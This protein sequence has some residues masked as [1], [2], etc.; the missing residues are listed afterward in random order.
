MGYLSSN[1]HLSSGGAAPGALSLQM[2]GL[3]WNSDGQ[4]KPLEE[5]PMVFQSESGYPLRAWWQDLPQPF[6]SVS[7][8]SQNQRILDKEQIID[9]RH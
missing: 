5:G 4:R 2:P 3:P 7:L 8:E 6:S 9:A 1:F